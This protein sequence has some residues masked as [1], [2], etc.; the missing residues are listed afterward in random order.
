MKYLKSLILALAVVFAVS[1]CGGG[2]GGNGGYEGSGLFPSN[3]SLADATEDNGIEVAEMLVS[4]NVESNSPDFRKYRVLDNT[5]SSKKALSALVLSQLDMVKSKI[6]PKR[7]HKRAKIID[8][9]GVCSNGGSYYKHGEITKEYGGEVEYEYNNCKIGGVLYDGKMLVKASDYDYYNEEFTKIDIEYK[10]D[11]YTDD[12]EQYTIKKG[13]T[14]STTLLD[15]GNYE[16]KSTIVS[17]K[18][19]KTKGFKDVVF[20]IKSYSNFTYLYQTS[21]RI[22]IN[23]LREYVVLDDDY[24]MSDTPFKYD[25]TNSLKSGEA[26]YLMR[27]GKLKISIENGEAYVS[28]NRY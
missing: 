15:N 6:S 27:G 14:I 13:S 11:F 8:E 20:V 16:V 5:K 22:Y 17:R 21:G 4:Y 2:A 10:S 7:S 24:D 18:D 9:D 19:G 23:N 3:S 1:G 25:N 28:I 26:R 12:G